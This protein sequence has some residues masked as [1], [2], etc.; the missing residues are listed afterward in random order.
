MSQWPRGPPYFQRWRP[1]NARFL[2]A[3]DQLARQTPYYGFLFD[4]AAVYPF[5]FQMR[6]RLV[7]VRRVFG[8]GML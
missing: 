8:V 3:F 4:S 2:G 5:D 6:P 1:L 7:G